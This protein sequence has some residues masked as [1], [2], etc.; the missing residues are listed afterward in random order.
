MLLCTTWKAR[1]LTPEQSERMLT[2]WGKLEADMAAR[3][4]MERRCWYVYADGSGGLT[5]NEV[6]DGSGGDAFTLEL[7]LALGEFLEFDLRPVLDLEGAMPAI[8]AAQERARV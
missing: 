2:I 8:M 6:E 1:A 5:V 3:A 7:M 4:D